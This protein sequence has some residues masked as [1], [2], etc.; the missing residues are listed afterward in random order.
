MGAP[1]NSATSPLRR[2]VRDPFRRQKIADAA[3]VV[4]QRDGIFALT[5]RAVAAEAGVPLGSTT[6]YFEDLDALLAAAL[7]KINADELSGLDE[8]AGC[9]DLTTQLEDALVELVLGYTNDE[10]ERTTL[11]YEI[12]VVA[13]RRPTLKPLAQRWEDAF[14]AIL[15]SVLS[16]NEARIVIASFDAIMLYGL[17]LDEPLS[18]AWA[19]DYLRRILPARSHR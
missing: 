18:E 4:M 5:H 15:M 1:L 11:G 16:E 12:H 8:W 19:R 9:W 7:E 10:R 3:T 17:G 13:Y 14:A 6:Y 2:R